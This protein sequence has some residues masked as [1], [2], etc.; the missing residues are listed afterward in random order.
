M[1]DV[2][3]GKEFRCAR[4]RLP[5]PLQLAPA[6]WA[7]EPPHRT[8]SSTHDAERGAPERPPAA[9]SLPACMHA[10]IHAF[11]TIRPPSPP[12]CSFPKEEEAILALW[13]EAGAWEGGDAFHEQLKRTKGKPE[14]SFYGGL[15]GC[16]AVVLLPVCMH[17][18]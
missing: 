3:E 2:I 15:H 1:K 14:Y 13:H 17:A 11:R 5:I 18:W 12:P 4:G 8:C 9:V 7:A 10:C 6:C 16:M